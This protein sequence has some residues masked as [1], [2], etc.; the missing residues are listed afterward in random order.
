MVAAAAATAYQADIERTTH[1]I[2]EAD[3]GLAARPND[4]EQATLQAYRWYHLAS[5][6]GK[7]RDFVV[8]E[9]VARETIERFGPREDLCLL[10]AN[11]DLR[12]HRLAEVR[13]DLEMTPLLKARP[14]A[15]SIL[16][17]VDFQEGRYEQARR[18]YEALIELDPV[19]DDMARLAHFK[20]KMGDRTGAEEWFERAEDELTAK[21]MRSFAWLELQRGVLD[22]SCG[23]Y[24]AARGH[25]DRA[26][27]AY[28][29]YWLVDEHVAELLAAEER[30]EE[31]EALYLRLAE[32]ESRPELLQTIG[33]LYGF[34]GAPAKAWDFLY[35]ALSA[36][37][38]SAER[39]D[40]H[41]W[42]HLSDFY[43][44]VRP[45]ADEAV[46]WARKDLELRE[47]FNTQAA[48]A[49]ALHVAGRHAEAL[50]WIESALASGVR[51]A[52]I[53]G[54]AAAVYHAAGRVSEAARY[55]LEAARINPHA[56]RFHVHR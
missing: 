25:Y 31:A 53:F 45:N 35:R 3:K 39:G 15:R 9:R 4:I 36:Y 29:G 22:L 50:Q 37:L 49:L 13:A 16:A 24:T 54:H 10:K 27:R 47:N 17:D 26:A 38:E 18:E 42:H 43:S 5:L 55:T 12:F 8:A 21:Q 48:M 46:K 11:L 7:T 2:A 32:R 1:D 20:W 14:Q 40:V 56:D 30:F 41:Y 34:M 44:D 33:E 6:G 23:D 28:S 19:W 52:H 51:D